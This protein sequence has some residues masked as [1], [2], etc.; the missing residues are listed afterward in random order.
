MRVCLAGWGSGRPAWWWWFRKAEGEAGALCRARGCDA[1]RRDT[2]QCDG[3]PSVP[4]KDSLHTRQGLPP[5]LLPRGGRFLRRSGSR[6]GGGGGDGVWPI[7]RKSR[8]SNRVSPVQFSEQP[9]RRPLFFWS[10]PVYNRRRHKRLVVTKVQYCNTPNEVP[11]S[12]G[13]GFGP[14]DGRSWNGRAREEGGRQAPQV[15]RPG[16]RA[17]LT[18]GLPGRPALPPPPPPG[19]PQQGS[20]P[21]FVSRISWSADD[22]RNDEDNNRAGPSPGPREI[23]SVRRRVAWGQKSDRT[24]HSTTGDVRP[25]AKPRGRYFRSPMFQRLDIA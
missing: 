25:R 14:G 13:H 18:S 3:R 24:S 9:R 2:T 22:S 12:P 21:T 23:I 17:H 1:V 5:V 10:F 7:T 8:R 20:D 19:S 11:R 4:V 16:G 15:T 6:H